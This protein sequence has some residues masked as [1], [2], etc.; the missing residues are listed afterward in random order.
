MLFLRSSSRFRNSVS[1]LFSM[2]FEQSIDQRLALTPNYK[3][4]RKVLPYPDAAILVTAVTAGKAAREFFTENEKAVGSIWA[5]RLGIP[6]DAIDL[7]DNFQDLGGH[8]IRAQQI[9]F[10][11]NRSRGLALPV[12]TLLQNPTIRGFASV[13]DRASTHIVNGENTE[14]TPPEAD[15]ALDGEHLA[16]FLPTSY[17]SGTVQSETILVTGATGFLG[18]SILEEILDRKSAI[19]VIAIVRAKTTNDALPR[20]KTTCVAYGEWSDSWE[21]R[22]ECLTGDLS[23]ER[24]GIALDVWDRLA[25]TVDVIIHNGAMYVVAFSSCGRRSPP[26]QAS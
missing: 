5:Q 6:A 26:V 3:L 16:T 9:V 4:D 23:R 7:N 21:S 12:K 20:V 19:K 1:S 11:V 10:D 22:I 24:F 18:S 14:G 13:I 17:P 15:Y 25:K 8:S 2:P